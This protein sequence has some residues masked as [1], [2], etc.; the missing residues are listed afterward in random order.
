MS[1]LQ[2]DC[3]SSVGFYR[4]LAKIEFKFGLR[5]SLLLRYDEVHQLLLSARL[6][7]S[8]TQAPSDAHCEELGPSPA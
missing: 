4:F 6:C 3:I 1:N 7:Q 8:L 5:L 2:L